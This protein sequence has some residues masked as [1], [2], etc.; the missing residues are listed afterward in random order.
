VKE[1]TESQEQCAFFRWCLK[2][3]KEFD[4]LR[5]IFSIPN[6]GLR[7]KV[8]ANR[9]KMEGLRA[10]VP[11]MCLPVAKGGYHALYIELKVRSG[12]KLSDKQDV[13]HHYLRG[14]GNKVVVCKGFKEA[15]QAVI[16]YYGQ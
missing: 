1:P 6:G 16:D 5:G 15:R 3:D 14:Q 10:G 7:D 2:H 4:G 11:D 8:N 12:G 9:L 13:W